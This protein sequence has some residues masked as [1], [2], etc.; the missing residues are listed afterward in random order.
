MRIANVSWSMLAVSAVRRKST[1]SGASWPGGTSIV[2]GSCADRP[3]APSASTHAIRYRF[4]MILLHEGTG[5]VAASGLTASGRRY[6][7]PGAVQLA[8]DHSSSGEED[9]AAEDGVRTW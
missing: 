7:K 2:V 8:V 5:T 6:P 3:P 1:S 9:A 4:I